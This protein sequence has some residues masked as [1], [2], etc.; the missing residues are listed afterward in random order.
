[1]S[2][3]VSAA[4]KQERLRRLSIVERTLAERY[5]RSLAGR[6]VEVLT[7][8]V[9]ADGEGAANVS[10]TACRYV[11]VRLSGC[12]AV[13]GRLVVARAQRNEGRDLVALAE[14]GG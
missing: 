4:V 11:P 1:M 5:C 3:Q 8:R 2:E 9:V 10:G 7:E 14:R 13:P 12:D 6:R